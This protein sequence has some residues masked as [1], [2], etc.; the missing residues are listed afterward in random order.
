MDYTLRVLVLKIWNQNVRTDIERSRR[1]NN[2]YIYELA[3]VIVTVLI[4]GI[5]LERFE[6]PDFFVKAQ[7]LNGNSFNF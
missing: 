1:F 2:I 3:D 5:H 6:Q 4:R 7:C